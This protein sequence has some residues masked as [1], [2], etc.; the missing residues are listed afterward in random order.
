[1]IIFLR[2]WLKELNPAVGVDLVLSSQNGA[3]L[4]Y[5]HQDRFAAALNFTLNKTFSGSFLFDVGLPVT[6]KPSP[7]PKNS[8]GERL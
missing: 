5:F 1:L 6:R 7:T 8:A 4:A 3:K 2:V